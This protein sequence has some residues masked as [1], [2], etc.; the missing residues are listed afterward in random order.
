[1]QA[2][3]RQ[4]PE[5]DQP[6]RP[7]RSIARRPKGDGLKVFFWKKRLLF[8]STFAL[9]VYEPWEK[10]VVCESPF[11]F[12]FSTPNKLFRALDT[13]VTLFAILFSAMAVALV[14]FLPQ[15]LVSMRQ[16][17]IY[18]LWGEVTAGIP[19]QL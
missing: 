1:M 4:C 13:K 14:T 3:Y 6:A 18:Y 15:R 17:T 12:T 19:S 11:C 8:E 5:L 16:R 7:D 9:T 10:A 2:L